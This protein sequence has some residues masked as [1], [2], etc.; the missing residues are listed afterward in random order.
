MACS[1]HRALRRRMSSWMPIY[2]ALMRDTGSY[3]WVSSVIVEESKTQDNTQTHTHAQLSLSPNTSPTWHVAS[4]G[5]R[6]T[7]TTSLPLN[8]FTFLLFGTVCK[9]LHNTMLWLVLA[10]LCTPPPP[11]HTHRGW[12][13]HHCL[14][15]TSTRASSS[16]HYRWFSIHVQG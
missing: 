4:K 16:I 7:Y 11:P 1:P 10:H 6:G 5:C 13:L 14:R 2:A 15:I 12:W 9:A 8:L 3:G